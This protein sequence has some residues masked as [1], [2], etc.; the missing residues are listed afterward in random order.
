[1]ST[2]ERTLFYGIY[3]SP[4][5]SIG[6]AATASGL[7]SLSLRVVHDRYLGHL[8]DAYG[9][10][11]VTDKGRLDRHR[12]FL[13]RYFAGKRIAFEGPF[14]LLHGTHFQRRVWATLLT[15]PYGEVKSYRWLAETVGNPGA[16]RAV[17]AANGQNPVAILIPCH[18]VI[19]H[20]G[21]LGGYSG[22]LDIKRRLL[23]LEQVPLDALTPKKAPMNG[24][25]QLLKLG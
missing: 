1:M 25:Q 13:D 8:S 14:D 23:A 16:Y 17:G 6:L 7:S 21:S 15:I 11:V 12:L 18:R 2:D 3:D 19:N 24:R 9:C 5:G 20:N 10:R 22:G 4:L